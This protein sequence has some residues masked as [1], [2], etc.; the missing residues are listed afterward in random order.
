MI[1]RAKG[2]ELCLK[3]TALLLAG[4]LLMIAA[5]DS[6]N[7]ISRSRPQDSYSVDLSAVKDYSQEKDIVGI[8]FWRNGAPY[9]NALIRVGANILPSTGNGYYSAQSPTVHLA[10]GLNQITFSDTTGTY[11]QSLTIELPDSFGITSVNPQYNQGIS[12]VEVAWTRPARAAKYVLSIVSRNYP[13]NGTSPLVLILNSDVTAFLVPD[14]TFEN[15]S[16]FPVIDTYLI[17]IA[18]FNEGFGEYAGMPFPLPPGLPQRRVSDPAGLIRYGTV[19]PVDS[20][21]VLP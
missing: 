4:A 2:K 15:L 11:S 12:N 19:A 17:Y 5:C 8:R 10:S 18:A 14:T 3:T 1:A 13:G 21:V 7:S 16:G 9:S 20:I 6:R